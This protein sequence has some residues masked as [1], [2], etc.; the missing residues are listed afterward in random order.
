MGAAP[1]PR[2]QRRAGLLS[3]KI[4]DDLASLVD[5]ERRGA[6]R[7]WR[8]VGM[9]DRGDDAFLVHQK[10]QD[11]SL[12]IDVEA[13]HLAAV[14]D[15]E[16]LGRLGSRVARNIDRGERPVVQQEPVAWSYGVDVEAHDPAA[17]VDVEGRRSRGAGDSEGREDTVVQQKAMACSCSVDV[18]AD[19]LAA[20]VDVEE[21]RF[22]GGVRSVDRAEA[23]IVEQKSM[24]DSL[25]IAVG[26]D[27]LAAVVDAEDLGCP[28]A[29]GIDGR[30]D[31]VVEQ[32]PVS[33]S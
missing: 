7:R 20:V 28:G 32:K 16:D 5:A 27:H 19:D 26:A 23:T 15:A 18:A 9:I 33:E 13:Y 11:P 14:I 24:D 8:G 21:H 6:E 30:E 22:R 4:S 31:A 25:V 12:G 17:V 3:P 1:A 2:S 29:W 10:A